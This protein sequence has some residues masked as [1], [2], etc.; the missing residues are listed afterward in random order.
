M[1][2]LLYDLIL[3]LASLILVPYY[4]FR[5]VRSG[6]LRQGIGERLGRIPPAKLSLLVRRQVFWIH[7]VSVGE[8]RAAVPLVKGLKKAYPDVALVLSSV[9][10]T[11]HEIASNLSQVDCCLFFPF[12]FSWVV[13]RVLAAIRPELIIIVETEIWPNFVRLADEQNIPVV[14]VNGRISDRSFPRYRRF[15]WFLRRILE[16][17]SL[18][19]MQTDQDA[20]RIQLMGAPKELVHVS[21][22]MKFDLGDILPGANI[23]AVKERY[24]L[25]DD[26]LIWIAGSTHAGEEEEV[27][28]A[29]QQLLAE[30]KKLFLVLVPRHPNRCKGVGEMLR[31]RGISF[32]RRSELPVTASFLAAGTVLLMDTVG[33]LQ[34][35]YGVADVVFVGGSLVPVGG[36]NL[37]EASAVKKPVLF[38]P[39]MH[40]FK[41]ISRL[42]LEAGGGLMVADGNELFT[43]MGRLLDSPAERYELG[44]R[45]YQVVARHAGATALTID[46][47]RS[48]LTQDAADH[49]A[50]ID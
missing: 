29:Y 9:T 2:Y 25:P 35:L 28:A 5:G 22:N 33:E 38:G 40:N 17:F 48:V 20:K 26:A 37:L 49:N 47:I 42:L 50:A 46:L 41:E 19:C 39:Q 12:D 21:G 15:R 6:T 4:A 3:L 8:T 13:R 14:L 32:A 18:L 24:Q 23:Q 30:G 45:G 31:Q 16:R 36:H 1:V 44:E 34:K 11:G 27:V 7:A 43:V 10:E